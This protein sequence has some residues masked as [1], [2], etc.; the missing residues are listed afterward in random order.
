MALDYDCGVDLNMQTQLAIR[1][2]G[3][4]W[5]VTELTHYVRDMFE[6][7]RQLHDVAVAGELS[8]LSRPRSGHLYFSLK[9]ADATLQCVMWRS[10]V[11]RLGFLPEDGDRVVAYGQVSVYAVAGRYQLYAT[12]LRPAGVGELL[13]QLEELKRKL[14]AEGLFD[15]ERKKPLPTLSARIALVTSPTGAARQDMRCVL[16]RRWPLAQVELVGTAVQGSAAPDEIVAALQAADR[17]QP[18]VILLG[19]GG[20]AI[21][22]LWAFN[23]EAV[24]RAIAATSAPV[25][26]G[27]G[28]ETDFTLADLAADMRA[29]TPS[30]AAEMATPDQREL[31]QVLDRKSQRLAETLAL[32][33]HS[34]RAALIE[35]DACFHGLSPRG[36]LQSARQHLH[37]L[38]RQALSGARNTLRLRRRDAQR[39]DQTLFALGPETTLA[40]GYAIVTRAE[41]AEIVRRAGALSVG[42]ALDVRV[43]EGR[44]TAK[45]AGIHPA[46]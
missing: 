2:P 39:I 14:S 1:L 31:R 46:E 43:A 27:I 16:A 34:C 45:V 26:T 29:P 9:D 41:T 10:E 23:S 4:Q 15:A 33:I 6:S 17:S 28:H 13:V 35:M 7:D 30:A 36:Q 12:A 38:S 21:E 25:V 40:R 19:R 44:F 18:D 3:E 5:S 32:Q 42:E 22:D 24:V 8:N 37:H 20:G 11:A